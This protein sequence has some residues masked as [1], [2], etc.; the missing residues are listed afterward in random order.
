MLSRWRAVALLALTASVIVAEEVLLSR[1]LSVT[2]WYSLAFVV[3]NL[4]MLGLTAGS[5]QAARA[6][7][8][9]APLEP[10]LARRMLA[11]GGTLLVADI[12]TVVT[13]LPFQADPHSFAALLL[14]VAVNTAPFI[15][16]GSVIARL[17][18]RG[19][20]SIPTLYEIGRASCR[21]RV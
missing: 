9:G 5:L 18:S 1:V 20:I 14:I 6:E 4:A 16:G 19:G 2:T 15:A 7:R 21:E 3:I 8:D 11:M 13:P 12:V 10:W 17:M